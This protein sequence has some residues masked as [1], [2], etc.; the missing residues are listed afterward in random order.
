MMVQVTWVAG[1]CVG[2]ELPTCHHQIMPVTITAQILFE[3]FRMVIVSNHFQG[4]VNIL[5]FYSQ[6]LLV[7]A[8]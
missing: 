3:P 1:C 7:N 8:T 5:Q 6:G 2:T 4:L